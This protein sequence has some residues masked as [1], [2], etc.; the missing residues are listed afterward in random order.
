M[1]PVAAGSVTGRVI[2]NVERG[3][4]ASSSLGLIH[5]GEEALLTCVIQSHDPNASALTAAV[6]EGLCA[7]IYYTDIVGE[8]RQLSV[9]HVDPNPVGVRHIVV[10]ID[11]HKSDADF[12]IGD[13]VLESRIPTSK[14]RPARLPLGG[15]GKKPE[16]GSMT[17]LVTPRP[18]SMN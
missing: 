5:P 16:L 10:G 6:N 3:I 18:L 4:G 9:L 1:A 11:V 7:L 8:Q 15:I 14:S 13:L 12:N 2:P 17:P